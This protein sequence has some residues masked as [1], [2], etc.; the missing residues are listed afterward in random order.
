MRELRSGERR[1]RRGEG[2][3][4]SVGGRGV[5]QGD[6][7]LKMKMAQLKLKLHMQIITVQLFDD[8]FKVMSGNFLRWKTWSLA[9][10]SVSREHCQICSRREVI[11]FYFLLSRSRDESCRCIHTLGL[12]SWHNA[13]ALFSQT[14]CERCVRVTVHFN[15]KYDI[16]GSWVAYKKCLG[17][18]MFRSLFKLLD[19]ISHV[20]GSKRHFQMSQGS[21]FKN[22]RGQQSNK[23]RENEETD[24]K[25]FVY[26]TKM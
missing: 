25:W 26:V 3:H 4:H 5:R 22:S 20:Q 16:N 7:A 14:N 21:I 9:E 24:R 8:T 15:L 11:F 13:Y 10:R 18:E 6:L 2:S 19:S 17:Q 1:A 12:L 23:I